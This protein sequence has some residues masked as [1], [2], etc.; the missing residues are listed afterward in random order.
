[1]EE[2]IQEKITWKDGFSALDAQ[3]FITY[4]NDWQNFEQ[5]KNFNFYIFIN[6]LFFSRNSL[7]LH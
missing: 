6:I 5:K 1:M 4:L 3:L 7:S 2:N